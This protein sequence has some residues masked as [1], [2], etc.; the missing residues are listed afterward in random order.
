MLRATLCLGLAL[1]G[2]PLAAQ[3]QGLSN[4]TAFADWTVACRAAAI[5]ETDCVLSQVL[6]KAETNELVAEVSLAP[7]DDD[8]GVVLLLRVPTGVILRRP[9]EVLVIGTE[10]G[11]ALDWLTCDSRY[12]TAAT[13]L[14]DATLADFRRGLTAR[15]GYLRM[16][17]ETPAVFDVSLRGVTAGLA[18]LGASD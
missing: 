7:A 2:G 5:G 14:Q 12:C 17:T 6:V 3:E 9:A 18:A 8:A 10:D 1:A 16:G 13:T 4:G 11:A 15:L